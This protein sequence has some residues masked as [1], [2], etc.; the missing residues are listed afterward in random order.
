MTTL[1]RPFSYI[2]RVDNP[3][4]QFFSHGCPSTPSRIHWKAIRSVSLHPLTVNFV[5]FFVLSFIVFR[6]NNEFLFYGIDGRFETTLIQQFFQFSPSLFGFAGDALR[7][8][9]N[10]AFPVNPYWIP[11]YIL[12]I[13]WPNEYW[14]FAL[15]YAINSSELFIAAYVIARLIQLPSLVGIL[16]AWITPL[17][18]MPYF[19]FGLVPHTAAAFPH[20]GTLLAATSILAAILA[21]V[22]PR[23]HLHSMLWALIFVGC[24]GYL[25]AIAPAVLMLGAPLIAVVI[26]VSL[27]SAKTRRELVLKSLTFGLIAV[28][29]LAAYGPYLAGLFLD[30]AANFFRGLSVRPAIL[31]EVSM[32]FWAQFPA[33]RIL[34][35]G[36][37]TGALIIA[38]F[39]NGRMQTTAI[40][41]LVTESLL[42]GIGVL[43]FVWPFWFGPALWYF[44]GFLY[45]YFAIFFIAGLYTVARLFGLS[46]VAF[47]PLLKIHPSA[48]ASSLTWHVVGFSIAAV[49]TAFVLSR[50]TT[51]TAGPGY[52]PIVQ[53]ET[54][55][56]KILKDEISLKSERQF[57]GRVADFV[58][59]SLPENNNFNIWNFLRFFALRSTGNMHVGPGL[60]QDAIP[61]L[62]EYSPH[63]TPAYFAFI[64]R[65][66]TLADDIQTRNLVQMRNIE[67]RLLAATGVRF[68]V[69]DAEF[70]GAALLRTQIPIQVSDSLMSE[71][72]APEEFRNH[73]FALHLYEIPAP[74]V[75]DYSPTVALLVKDAA[76]A[77]NLLGS[78]AF[79]PKHTV[80]TH[81]AIADDLKPAKLQQFSVG[82]GHFRVRAT[83]PG[84]SLLLLP[85]EF[86]S[87][88][89]ITNVGANPDSGQNAPRL[90]RADLLLTGLLFRRSVDVTVGYFTGPFSN[91]FCR[92]KDRKEFQALAISNAFG[93]RPEFLPK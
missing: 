68:V 65:F 36:G 83:S 55:I 52:I 23:T 92:L 71:F 73:K 74:N 32:I 91:S 38:R 69:T 18:I 29:C 60:W 13:T 10:M 58:G 22:N 90:I 14:N 57:R 33:G 17:V 45:L 16:A 19:G 24:V 40:G 80:V 84:R 15:T 61:T 50:G 88:L 27:I 4:A 49:A 78:S 20:Y 63:M 39:G 48:F 43:Q 46:L 66:F 93:D 34:I 11:G 62:T 59:R 5:V 47:V 53:A 6:R 76:K 25:V 35:I 77:L 2:T 75:G 21:A 3:L 67:P 26:I 82:R 41:L 12:A 70:E 9:G 37:M 87:C 86:S 44:E 56:T 81:E 30:T 85:I 72:Y 7:G 51:G 89:R 28:T 64:R 31:Q 79:D 54:A 8:L 1:S 42:L